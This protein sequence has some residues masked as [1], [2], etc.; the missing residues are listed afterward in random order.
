[1]ADT[2][3]A[4]INT[5]FAS[6]DLPP[7][8][9]LEF[10]QTG[11]EAGLTSF[12][13]GDH[14]NW[15][16][17][18]LEC[19]TTL[20]FV[21]GH[22]RAR[23]GTNVVVAALRDP[24]LLA[25]MAATID[26]LAPGGLDLGVGIGG[27]HAIEFEAADVPIAERGARTDEALVLIRRLLHEERVDHD[28]RFYRTRGA[29]VFPRRPLRILVGGRSDPAFR[30]VVEHGDG[31]SAAWVTPEQVTRSLERISAL[32]EERGRDPRSLR[33]V[34]HVFVYI[35]DS[36]AEA[37]RVASAFLRNHYD[38]DPAPFER[39]CAVGHADA[40]GET[41]ANYLMTDLDELL[42]SF[43]GPDPL[44]QMERYAQDVL[45]K[46]FATG[47]VRREPAENAP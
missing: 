28:G 12:W 18:V 26:Y 9:I 21:A 35:D 7:E 36:R 3:G 27:E 20:A 32:A 6:R 11:E 24:V 29:R 15:Y 16:V 25:K 4:M 22:T 17:P 39:F 19:L 41:L 31:W 38:S 42:V 40:V 1:M 5:I 47:R 2:L 43:V 37:W 46:L 30:R 34:A 23:V 13:A 44:A 14:L 33:S 45:P 10:V 8:D